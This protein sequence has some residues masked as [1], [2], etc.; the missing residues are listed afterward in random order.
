MVV[1]L[2]KIKTNKFKF[3]EE[4]RLNFERQLQQRTDQLNQKL[5]EAMPRLALVNDMRNLDN[6]DSYLEETR[7]LRCRLLEF[8]E[9]A[10][11]INS[12]EALFK[13][14]LSTYPE[15]DEFQNCLLPVWGL[16]RLCRVWRTTFS[17]WMDGSFDEL[18]TDSIYETTDAMLKYSAH[19][20]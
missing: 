4:Q 18:D 6:I 3:F 13:F 2:V 11:W 5:E 14:P 16:L 8:E 17:K 20:V 12:E 7:K 9:E 19:R 15:L 10:A 1:Y